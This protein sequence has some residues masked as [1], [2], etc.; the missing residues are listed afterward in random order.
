VINQTR[1]SEFGDFLH[2]RRCVSVSIHSSGHN[3]SGKPTDCEMILKRQN[4]GAVGNSTIYKIFWLDF[5]NKQLGD[6]GP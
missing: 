4:S 3:N 2:G 6:E 5:T 1:R